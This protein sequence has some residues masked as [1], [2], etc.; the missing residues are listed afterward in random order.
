MASVCDRER[1]HRVHKHTK[2]VG[3]REGGRQTDWQTGACE[4]LETWMT[5]SKMRKVRVERCMW[6]G[7]ELNPAP[8][9]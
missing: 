1:G 3:E 4:I 7:R 9:S 6:R 5:R 2:A 8:W